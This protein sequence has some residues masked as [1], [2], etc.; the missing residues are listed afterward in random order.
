M[1]NQDFLLKNLLVE[2]LKSLGTRFIDKETGR[3]KD[4]EIIKDMVQNKELKNKFYNALI[5]ELK[6]ALKEIYGIE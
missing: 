6:L 3:Y 2:T 1:R 4:H 5:I